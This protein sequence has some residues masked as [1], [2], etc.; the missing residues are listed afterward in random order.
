MTIKREVLKKWAVH[1]TFVETGAYDGETT[2][3]ATTLFQHV[4]TIELDPVRAM[5]IRHRLVGRAMVVQG[6]SRRELP[7]VLA[8]VAGPAVILLDAHWCGPEAAG[9]ASDPTLLGELE[10]LAKLGRQGDVIMVDDARLFGAQHPSG[11][12]GI[13]LHRVMDLLRAIDPELRFF[14]EDGSFPADVLVASRIQ[15]PTPP[16]P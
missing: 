6:D 15:P 5:A 12:Q 11:W 14:F 2:E 1:P 4:T 13:T 8:K 3:L 9:D 10:A 16:T 7:Y